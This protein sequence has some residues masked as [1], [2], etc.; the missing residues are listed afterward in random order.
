MAIQHEAELGR[1]ALKLLAQCPVANFI[2]DDKTDQWKVKRDQL[3]EVWKHNSDADILRSMTEGAKKPELVEVT[4]HGE[5]GDEDRIVPVLGKSQLL[6]I[7]EIFAA[8][9]DWPDD[10]EFRR[11]AL[12]GKKL[13]VEHT[14]VI[15]DEKIDTR[16]MHVATLSHIPAWMDY[17]RLT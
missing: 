17:C 12:D 4:V 8:C 6:D 7:P 9:N 14:K 1:E 5:P 10:W 15:K 13:I 2:E 16:Q 11:F 3:L